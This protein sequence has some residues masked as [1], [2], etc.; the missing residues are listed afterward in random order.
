MSKMLS[1]FIVNLPELPLFVLK[2]DEYKT[3]LRN[4]KWLDEKS[5]LNFLKKYYFSHLI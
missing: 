3:A 4:E 5:K 1:D 2:D